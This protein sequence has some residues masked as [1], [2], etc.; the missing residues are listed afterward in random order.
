LILSD[1]LFSHLGV[2]EVTRYRAFFFLDEHER[3]RFARVYTGVFTG[4]TRRLERVAGAGICLGLPWVILLLRFAN[5]ISCLESYLFLYSRY[6]RLPLMNAS[7]SGGCD[8]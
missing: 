1:G 4:N 3:G 5:E 2:F 8:H 6:F 7:A